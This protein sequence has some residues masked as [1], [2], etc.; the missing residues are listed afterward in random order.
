MCGN[1]IDRKA[2]LSSSPSISQSSTMRLL[3][4]DCEWHPRPRPRAARRVLVN[5][6]DL[7]IRERRP[8]FPGLA[9]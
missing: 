8:V 1:G 7:P 5:Q 4:A 6:I 2:L 3:G 9:P